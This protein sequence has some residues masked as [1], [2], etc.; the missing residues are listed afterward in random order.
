[1]VIQQDSEGQ[2][3]YKGSGKHR[4]IHKRQKVHL[5]KKCPPV[6]VYASDVRQLD[7]ILAEQAAMY[8]HHPVVQHMS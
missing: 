8:D 1:M 2:K 7:T 4:F 6:P 5:C 3:L